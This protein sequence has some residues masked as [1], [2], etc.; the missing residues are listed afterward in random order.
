[1]KDYS[2][3]KKLRLSEQDDVADNQT[4]V[5]S[6]AVPIEVNNDKKKASLPKE[7][8]V[9]AL[10]NSVLFPNAVLPVTIGRPASRALVEY[11]A[12]EQAL[13]VAATQLDETDTNPDI[14]ALNPIGVTARVVKLVKLPDGSITVILNGFERVG[15]VEQTAAEPFLR[16]TVRRVRDA[17]VPDDKQERLNVILSAIRD[18]SS[19]VF[20]LMENISPEAHIAVRNISDPDFLVNLVASSLEVESHV[21]L[22]LLNRNNLYDR[23]EALIA[24]VEK[25]LQFLQLKDDIQSKARQGIDRQQ[26]E[27]MLHEMTRT[28]QDELGDNPQNVLITKYRSQAAQKVWSKTVQEAFDKELDRF[29]RLN[30]NSPEYGISQNYLDAMVS[31]P[32]GYYSEDNLDLNRAQRV[33]DSRH[34]GMEKVKE[35][36]LEHLAVLKLKGDLKS[37]ILCLYGPPGVGKTSL[38]KSVAE[39]LDRKFVRM[40]L[41]GLH[42]EAEIRGHRRTYIGAMPGRII[43]NIRL[44]GTS[45]PVF[46]LDEIDKVSNDYHGDPASALLEVLDP[47]QNTA[48]HDNFLDLDYDLS[49]VLFIATANNLST[50]PAPLLDRMELIP[51]DGYLLEEKI[52]IAQRHL[53]PKEKENNGLKDGQLNLSD[54]TVSYLIEKYTRES[55]VRNLDKEIAHL[56]RKVA[57]EVA[58][59]KEASPDIQPA[60]VKRLLGNEKFD[61]DIWHDDLPA[62]V[63]TGLAWTAV[64]GEILFVECAASAGKGKMT[65]TG[66][67]GD[68]MKESAILAVELVRSNAANFG[69]KGVDFDNEN[70]HIHVPEG[71]VPKD[72]PSAGVTMTTAI[73]SALTGRRVRKRIAMTGE[74]TLRGMVLPV[75][76]ITEKILAAKRAGITDIILCHENE[77]DIEEIKVEYVR[78]LNF[79]YV[80]NVSEVLNIALE[81]A[82]EDNNQTD[83]SEQ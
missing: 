65:L 30:S 15:I 68:V 47:E 45:N 9:M 28:I 19:D 13:F 61:H 39:A 48:F 72:G 71:A 14:A 32:W 64:G 7:L 38:G 43:E 1:M 29:S 10:R 35:R 52:Q 56:C 21:K 79:H 24:V 76:G 8:P 73:V 22:D 63:V 55:G 59:G 37:P 23:A 6:G 12:K 42:D 78:G 31:L 70:F 34:Y 82:K 83:P 17:K 46:I 2:K 60:D 50:I 66:N 5:T 26:R 44:A 69:I 36:V 41:G 58:K 40:S 51:V 80:S 3:T 25:Q 27:Y 81:P 20:R 67:L 74:I 11:V 75:G 62:G 18:K 4:I 54:D 33:L 49:K 57:L 16:A 77:K 53:I